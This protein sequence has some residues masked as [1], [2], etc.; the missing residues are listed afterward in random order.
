VHDTLVVIN[1]NDFGMT[2]GPA[3]FDAGGN[4]VD[5]GIETTLVTIR[6]H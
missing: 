5:S 2:D 3:A 1:D 4:L 6:L